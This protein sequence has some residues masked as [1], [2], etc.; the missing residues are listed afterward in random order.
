MH[1]Q[2]WLQYLQ[3][4]STLNTW[5]DHIT[6]HAVANTNNLRIDIAESAPNFWES[7]TVSSIYAK[8]ENKRRNQRDIYVGHLDELHYVSTTHITQ[9]IS[10]EITYQKTRDRPRAICVLISLKAHQIFGSQQ[11]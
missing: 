11:L 1:D 7:T 5:A 8:S 4:M 9:S 10:A 3:N 6:I 2:S